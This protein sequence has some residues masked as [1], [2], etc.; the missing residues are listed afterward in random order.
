MER[1]R[2]LKQL[3]QDAVDQGSRAVERL[4]KE[5]AKRPF[6]LLEQIPSIQVPVKGIREIHDTTVTGVHG[7]IRLVNRVAGDTVEVI[8]SRIEQEKAP[9]APPAATSGSPPEEPH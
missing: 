1:L 4:Q 5:A 2:G 8:L 7:V 6:D 9:P 3:V